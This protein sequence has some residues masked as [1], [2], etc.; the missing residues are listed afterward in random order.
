[1]KRKHFKKHKTHWPDGACLMLVFAAAFALNLVAYIGITKSLC[2]R[3][4]SFTAQD[5]AAMKL[6]AGECAKPWYAKL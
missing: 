6:D 2:S 5:Q 3:I 4:D 1:M